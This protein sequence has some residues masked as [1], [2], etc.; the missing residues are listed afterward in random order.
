MIK[1]VFKYLKHILTARHS[2]GFGIHSPFIF[3][4]VRNV[5]YEKSEYYAFG[6]IEK[7][8]KEL[9]NNTDVIQVTDFGTGESK[10]RKIAEIARK[11]LKRAKSAQLLYRTVNF[12]KPETIL[13]LGTSLGIT[14]C[15]LAAYSEKCQCTTIEGC[16]EIARIAENNFKELKYNNITLLN[17]E[18]DKI[19]PDFLRATD[20]LDFVFIDANHTSEALISY[21]N[22]CVTKTG[23]NSVFVADDIHWSDDM[24]T[25]WKYIQNHPSVKTTIDV[26]DMGIVFFNADL[27]KQHYRLC[28]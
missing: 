27:N 7:L 10:P 21:F 9:H 1:A 2:Y 13:E 6:A 28:Y 18:I 22:Q 4:Y 16:P 12:V 11:S 5:V 3:R 19:L 25:G 20:K 24:E 23:P 8:R 17:G 26:F 14:T 15:Y